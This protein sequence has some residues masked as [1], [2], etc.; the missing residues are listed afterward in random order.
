MS[1]PRTSSASFVD[2]VLDGDTRL[3]AFGDEV[4]AWQAGDQKRPLHTTLGLDAAELVLVA[5][6]PDALRYILHAR[7]FGRTGPL[8]LDSQPRVD[9]YSMRLAADATDPYLMA[10]VEGCRDVVERTVSGARDGDAD[11]PGRIATH[12]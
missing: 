10:E 8:N 4:R 6:S 5:R 11:A 2:R 3:D 7:R 12:A 1:R 9:A